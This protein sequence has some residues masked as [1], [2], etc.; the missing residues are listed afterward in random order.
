MSKALKSILAVLLLA[1]LA[2]CFGACSGEKTP[3]PVAS[4]VPESPSEPP[5]DWDAATVTWKPNVEF[6]LEVRVRPGVG[7]AAEPEKHYGCTFTL[8]DGRTVFL[9]VLGFDYAK[10]TDNMIGYFK[11]KQPE[12]FKLGK[13]SQAMIVVYNAEETEMCLKLA[14]EWCLTVLAPDA[15]TAEEFFSNVMI[16][17][18]GADYTPLPEDEYEEQT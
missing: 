16:K 4:S 1:A 5:S 3:A 13:A 10:D 11:Q 14:D 12:S 9:E 18:D 8:G 17:S 6:D 2:V 7:Y 15:A